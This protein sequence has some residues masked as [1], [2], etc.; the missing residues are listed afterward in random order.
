MKPNKQIR[1]EER[2]EP[3]YKLSISGPEKYAMLTAKVYASNGSKIVEGRYP[4]T[5]FTYLG[6]Q[7][8]IWRDER[9]YYEKKDLY[10]L[11]KEIEKY[12]AVMDT[13]GKPF[14]INGFL[15]TRRTGKTKVETFPVKLSGGTFDSWETYYEQ[16]VEFFQIDVDLENRLDK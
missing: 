15:F 7:Q 16:P 9:G 13:S 12:E 2:K 3:I 4:I 1:S 10:K 8:I 6:S 11:I 5:N 14:F